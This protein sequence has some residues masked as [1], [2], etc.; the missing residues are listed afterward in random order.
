MHM[1]IKDLILLAFGLCVAGTVGLIW[2]AVAATLGAKTLSA[3]WRWVSHHT[4]KELRNDHSHT[5][6]EG[7]PA[8]GKPLTWP[9]VETRIE[10]ARGD[11]D[12]KSYTVREVENDTPTAKAAQALNTFAV[13]NGKQDAPTYT[14]AF[15]EDARTGKCT[16]PDFRKHGPAC[17]HTALVVM[18]QWPGQLE[19]WQEQVH[20]LCAADPEPEPQDP[21]QPQDI[22]AL[23]REKVH[24]AL[25]ALEDTLVAAI[26]QDVKA[27]LVQ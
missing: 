21:Q 16:C 2:F 15:Y 7:R 5:G 3:A 17:K 12:A 19:R 4:R 8:M 20:A 10:R 14:V 11:L 6:S 24:D 27:A 13:R 23:V 22:E 25:A 26:A 18:G 9:E 1:E